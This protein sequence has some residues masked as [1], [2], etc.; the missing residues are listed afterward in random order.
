MNRRLLVTGFIL[1]AAAITSFSQ[2]REIPQPVRETFANQYPT[3]E[4]TD[5]KIY[6]GTNGV[7]EDYLEAEAWRYPEEFKTCKP[8][9]KL[10][11]DYAIIKLLSY[12]GGR[13]LSYEESETMI[14][15]SLQN[16]KS[17]DALQAMIARLKP[18]YD[19]AWR[20]ELLMLI[21]LVDPTLDHD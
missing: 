2:I 18:R 14:D 9:A 1:L 4:N 6:F 7:A 5:F 19:V 15:E 20:P 3:A 17:D 13:Q 21:K 16:K 11:H 8:S 10:P 12:D